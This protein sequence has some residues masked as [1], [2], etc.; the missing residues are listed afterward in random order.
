MTLLFQSKNFQS[1]IDIS[2]GERA[3]AYGDGH[4]TTAHINHGQVAF[5]DQHIERLKKANEQLKLPACDW[6]LLKEHLIEVAARHEQAVLKVMVTAGEGGRGY[7]RKGIEH[8]SV[9]VSV[10]S[11]P[12][13][14]LAWQEEGISIGFSEFKL[15]S[16]S[17]LVGLKHLNR[18]EQVMIRAELDVSDF[19]E[20]IVCDHSEYLIEASCA[21]LFWF[22][23]GQWHTPALVSSGIAGIIRQ[24]LIYQLK[25]K[26]QHFT[27]D[28]LANI[29]SMLICNS[30]MGIVPIRTL[31]GNDLSTAFA[32]RLQE[33]LS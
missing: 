14:Y 7:S 10:S 32:K 16:H 20:L 24:F 31:N 4:F 25:P 12:M 11:F 21:N 6:C 30:V 19:Q 17:A 5:L 1:K 22:K 33:M 9:Y 8:S 27:R 28:D 18:I 15:A 3:F 26:V 13:H 23:Q 29:D 2:M